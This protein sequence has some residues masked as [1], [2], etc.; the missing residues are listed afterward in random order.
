MQVEVSGQCQGAGCQTASQGPGVGSEW[1][2]GRQWTWRL[3]GWQWGPGC[4]VVV[5]GWAPD[6]GRGLARAKLGLSDEGTGV[7]SGP[8]N[9]IHHQVGVKSWG[10][11]T[12]H[13]LGWLL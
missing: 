6:L 7:Q 1:I 13:P 2:A 8:Q 12:L 10:L 11:T 4:R 3:G 9:R 5:L